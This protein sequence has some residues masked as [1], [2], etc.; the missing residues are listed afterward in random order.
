MSAKQDLVKAY[1]SWETLTQ[2]EGAAIER[3]DW[4]GVNACQ[5][6]KQEL[7]RRIILLT[8]VARAESV[9]AGTDLKIFD[10]DLR[11]MVNS[12][13]SLE[14]KN[15]ELLAQRRQTAELQR[16][17]LDQTSRTLRRMQKSYVAPATSVWQSYS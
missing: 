9:E 1:Q 5:K 14:T 7:Q 16:A 2:D 11:Q 10:K 17:E 4:Q 6:S 15:S 8:D 12:L 3:G 13:I